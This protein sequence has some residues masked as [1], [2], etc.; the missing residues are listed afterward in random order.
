M[1]TIGL[2]MLFLKER[3][4]KA[5]ALGVVLALIALPLFNFSPGE[6]MPRQRGCPASRAPPG[7]PLR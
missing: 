2:S 3:V 7:S 5:G 4:T 1:I 6:R